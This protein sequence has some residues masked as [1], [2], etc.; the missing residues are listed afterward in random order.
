MIEISLQK[1]GK[2]LSAMNLDDEQ[3]LSEYYDNQVL[4]CKIT[5]VKKPRSYEQLKLFWACCRTVSENTEDEHWDTIEK[6]S[7]QVKHALQ[8][9]D[10][11]NIIVTPAGKVKIPVRSISFKNLSHMAACNFFDRA[12]EVLAKKIGVTVE[13]LLSNANT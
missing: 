8:F 3:K 5:G 10:H 11:D 4:R 6:V 9:Y 1:T 12:F 7:E 2:V 13:E